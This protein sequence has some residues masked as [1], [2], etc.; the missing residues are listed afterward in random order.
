MATY[1]LR[2]GA[3]S[4]LPLLARVSRTLPRHRAGLFL[5]MIIGAL[6]AFELF[7]FGTTEYALADF[8]G[9][10]SFSGIRWATILA[11]AFCGMDFAG[12]ARMFTP[13]KD[14]KL[15]VESWYLFG[16]WLLAATMNALLTWWAVTLALVGDPAL[17]NEVLPRETLLSGAPVFV[18]M[19]VWLI[20]V[21]IIGSLAMSGTTVPGQSAHS[22]REEAQA[23]AVAEL[24]PA[25][26]RRRTATPSG[27]HAFSQSE[28]VP[29]PA[30][31][32]SFS[33]QSART[34]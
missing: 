14:R 12:I 23:K 9:D 10:L 20:R 32:A 11:L 15:W 18:A 7:N 8:L 33:G 21:L 28:P 17:G 19:L 34:S 24:R 16:A 1:P 29:S 26:L 30:R 31:Q 2:L 3:L 22:A 27:S 5:S 4:P 6:V 13:R 25:L